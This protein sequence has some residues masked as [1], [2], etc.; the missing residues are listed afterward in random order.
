MQSRSNFD[1]DV[2]RSPR[3]DAR[4]RFINSKDS[5]HNG[6]APPVRHAYQRPIETTSVCVLHL[7]PPAGAEIVSTFPSPSMGS[8]AGGPTFARKRDARHFSAMLAV[9]KLVE[10]RWMG[11]RGD[12]VALRLGQPG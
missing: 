9:S 8:T 6:Q 3:H 10:E 2:T 12:L 5:E 7:H 11:I 1:A 4:D